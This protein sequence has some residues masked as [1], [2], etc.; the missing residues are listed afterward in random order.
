MPANSHDQTSIF[1]PAP[2][3]FKPSI[4]LIKKNLR[5][6]LILNALPFVSAVASLFTKTEQRTDAN[7]ALE[8]YSLSSLVTILGVGGAFFLVIFIAAFIIATMSLS[9]QVRGSRGETPSLSVLFADAKKYWWRLLQL[10]VI[11]TLIVGIGL[12]CFIIPGVLLLRRY[13]LAPYFLFDK[14]FG[15]RESMD[16]SAK[17]SLIDTWQIYSVLLVMFLLFLLQNI[18]IFGEILSFVAVSMYSF[19]PAIRYR[20]FLMFN[21]ITH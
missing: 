21:K 16:Q 17:A 2:S 7:A 11:I 13:F 10:V 15:I 19:A 3:L 18:E 9:L 4:E 20:E 14:D 12:L 5:V 1:T 6:F 8:S